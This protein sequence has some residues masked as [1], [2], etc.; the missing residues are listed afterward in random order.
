[1]NTKLTLTIEKSIIERAKLYAKSTGRSLSEIIENYLENLTQETAQNELSPK[2]N[3][4]VGVVNLPKDFDE[5][6]ELRSLLLK[7]HS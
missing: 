7:K 6:V 4:L 2:L 3:K 1:M 5:K